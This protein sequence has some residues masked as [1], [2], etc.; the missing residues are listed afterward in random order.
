MVANCVS[1]L[2]SFIG[3]SQPCLNSS[4][5]F[6]F[7]HILLLF[8]HENLFLCSRIFL[9]LQLIII[10]CF[11]FGYLCTFIFLCMRSRSGS[12]WT[13]P[14]HIELISLSSQPLLLKWSCYGSRGVFYRLMKQC[15]WNGRLYTSVY[16]WCMQQWYRDKRL[17]GPR[18]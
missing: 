2:W 15:Q 11:V 3:K 6:S 7:L 9:L 13:P 18:R 1:P 12:F 10:I 16:K 5:L 8:W 14:L 17:E 4:M